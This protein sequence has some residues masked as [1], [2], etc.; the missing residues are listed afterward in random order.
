MRET[1]IDL[2]CV[3][4]FVDFRSLPSVSPASVPAPEDLAPRVSEISVLSYH[5]AALPQHSR[6]WI[7]VFRYT[8]RAKQ[9]KGRQF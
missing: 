8:L 7:F 9:T 1:A 3:T 6:K 5:F 4:E 2:I